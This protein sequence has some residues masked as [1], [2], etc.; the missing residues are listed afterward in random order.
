MLSML[1]KNMQLPNIVGPNSN[2]LQ[3]PLY[4]IRH[5]FPVGFWTVL[6]VFEKLG[7]IALF[8]SLLEALKASVWKGCFILRDKKIQ[9]TLFTV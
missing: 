1:L 9:N 4:K 5:L 7:D 6:Y 2:L 8:H 3:C